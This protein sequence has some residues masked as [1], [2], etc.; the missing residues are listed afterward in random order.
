MLPLDVTALLVFNRSPEEESRYKAITNGYSQGLNYRALKALSK[1]TLRIAGQS[2][3]PVHHIDEEHQVGNTFGE[4]FTNAFQQLFNA[5]YKRV[6]A[7]GNDHP[8]LSLQHIQ[9]A[10]EALNSHQHVLGPATDGGFYLMGIHYEAFKS[11]PFRQLPWQ[12]SYLQNA[13]R[14]QCAALSH[15]TF[16]L[17]PLQ[18]VDS[19]NDLRDLRALYQYNWLAGGLVHWLKSINPNPF[20]GKVLL[21]LRFYFPSCTRIFDTRGPPFPLFFR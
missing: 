3:I 20:A 7:I 12:Q 8:G 14:E 1:Q 15:S 5:G 19:P 17:P 6:I 16:R 11:L 4:R 2:G 13:Y 10:L 18:D 9:Q 21:I